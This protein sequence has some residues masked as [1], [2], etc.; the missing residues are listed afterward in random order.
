MPRRPLVTLTTDVGSAYAA[1]MKAVLYRSVPPGHVIDI[2]HDLLPHG[3]DEASFLLRQVGG[4]FPKGTVHIAVVDP[5]VGGAR[6]A[7]AVRCQEGSLL[8][9]PDNGVLYPLAQHLGIVE[10]V[11]LDPAR[12]RPRAPVSATFE[13]RD[14]FAP[15]AARLAKGA[16]LSALGRPHELSEHPLPL[17]VWRGAW[18]HGT[19]L[20][21]DR[22][23][24]AITNVPTEWFP[25]TS[26]EVRLRMGR[27]VR[28]LP[29]RR[30]YS[31]LEP[32]AI[33]VLG[34]SFGT[35]EVSARETS[36]AVRLRLAVGQRLSLRAD[37]DPGRR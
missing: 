29:R 3:I 8:V 25:Q 7:V 11:R 12:V 9:G 4:A 18:A 34:S 1:Q 15:A 24:N 33:G 37:L 5:G 31:E 16:K 32:R 27:Q 36:A 14:L 13:G 19:I 6:A 35:L 23:G 30:T 2:A 28:A 10:V 17:P 21:V 20:H 22:F 26:G